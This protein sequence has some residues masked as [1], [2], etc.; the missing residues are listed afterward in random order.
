MNSIVGGEF[1]IDIK[2]IRNS[3]PKLP[4][5]L[6][7]GHFYSSGRAALFHILNFSSQS[8]KNKILLPDYLC[9]S[10]IEV[11]KLASVQYKFY[12]INQ[13]LSLNINSINELFDTES[14][15]LI[16]NYFGVI[17]IRSEIQ[18]IK[19]LDSSAFIILDNVQSLY[20][21]FESFDVDFMFTSFRK[22]LPVPDGAWV[23]SKHSELFQCEEENTF[24]QYK[25]AGGLLKN[26]QEFDV[27]SD[28]L[29]LELF[30]KGENLIIKNINSKISNITLSILSVLDFDLIRQ[31][32]INNAMII[33]NG[34]QTMEITP[35][36]KFQVNTVPL[37]V[38]ILIKNRDLLRLE[39]RKNNIYC[40]VHWPKS[41]EI[42]IKNDN[43]YNSELSLI[44]D[45]RYDQK[46]MNKILSI[47]ARL[48]NNGK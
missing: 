4:K 44:I 32:R 40:P 46:V 19:N 43:L 30:E 12:T 17:D 15:I 39:L 27:F 22:Q 6:N 16:I 9:E 34:L 8:G 1:E 7:H 42:N 36:I 24:S 14:S 29:Y 13:D 38:P 48:V 18:K 26:Y 41:K 25:L 45:Q 3:S 47:I 31:K 37:F 21:M 20:S 5:K 11:V 33:I 35:I 23:V 2:I 28:Q 10:I